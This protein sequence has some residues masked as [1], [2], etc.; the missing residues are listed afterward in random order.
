[1]SS[2]N[3]ILSAL[4]VVQ[5]VLVLGMRLG[6]DEPLKLQ[7]IEVLPG[8]SADTVTKLEIWSAPKTDGGP[9]QDNVALE[10]TDGAW[11]IAG[12]E[13]FGADEAKVDELLKALKGLRSRTVVLESSTYHDKLEVSADTYQRKVTVIAG[14]EARTFYVGTSPSFKNVHVRVEG[15]DQVLLVNEF[16]ATQLGARAWNWVDK[17]YHEIPEDQVWAVEVSNAKGRYKLDK[18]PQTKAWTDLSRTDTLD[19]TTVSEIVR[20]A[21]SISLEA[22]VGKTPAPAYG[23]DAPLA[24]VTL[25]TGTS[26]VAG[27][28]PPST[29]TVT[30]TVGKKLDAEN[31]YYVKASNQ[32]YIVQVAGAGV[33]ALVDKGAADLVKTG[34]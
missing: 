26:T 3:K 13:G 6:E 31:R 32:P 33:D 24:T 29:E 18:D 14:G 9:K 20:K 4:L 22:P 28:P 8:F 2:L 7:T 25:T 21:R 19:A 27:L 10:K 23:L 11:T 30:V 12:T 16:G 34:E 15:S 5:V 17:S 1:M